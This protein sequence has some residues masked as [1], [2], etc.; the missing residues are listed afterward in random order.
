MLRPGGRLVAATNGRDHLR[1]VWTLAGDPGHGDG[2][3]FRAE[4]APAALATVFA[5]VECRPVEAVVVFPDAGAVRAYVEASFDPQRAQRVPAFA[6]P[7][8]ASGRNA[9]L[10]ATRA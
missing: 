4:E 10:V 8:R 9:V 2:L 1:E 3:P 5:S 6:G 7:L